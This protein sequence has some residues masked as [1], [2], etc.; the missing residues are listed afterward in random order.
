MTEKNQELI[1][2][3]RVQEKM[4][5]KQS[6]REE[7]TAN[8]ETGIA[9]RHLQKGE[10][11]FA[12]L[13]AGNA[14]RA[15]QHAQFLRENA[16]QLS[17]M[18]CDLRM[19]DLQAKTAKSLSAACKEMEKYIGQMNLE[20]IA[21]TTLKYDELRGK[22]NAAHQMLTPESDVDVMSASLLNDLVQE[23]MVDQE[24][25]TDQIPNTPIGEVGTKGEQNV[26][27]VSPQ[28]S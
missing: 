1:L 18:V 20:K 6:E 3:L 28:A 26:Y 14:V 10:R 4:L 13:H 27:G 24:M 15:R 17:Q 19:A 25:M 8:K 21:E 23:I 22:T 7:R 2:Q 16:A 9:K 11:A 12:Q 5:T